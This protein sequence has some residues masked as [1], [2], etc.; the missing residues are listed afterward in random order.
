MKQDDFMR[1]YHT[2]Q[3]ALLNTLMEYVEGLINRYVDMRI[4]VV[5]SGAQ[6]KIDERIASLRIQGEMYKKMANS[7]E[8]NF[9]Q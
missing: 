5:Y 7:I 2:G 9:I 6:K 8:M 3:L 4:S 1:G